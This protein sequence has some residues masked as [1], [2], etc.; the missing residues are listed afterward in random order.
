MRLEFPKLLATRA[1]KSMA[2]TPNSSEPQ[3]LVAYGA[4]NE[5]LLMDDRLKVLTL[6]HALASSTADLYMVQQYCISVLG[7]AGLYLVQQYCRSVLGSERVCTRGMSQV[8]VFKRFYGA[9]RLFLPMVEAGVCLFVYLGQGK[10]VVAWDQASACLRAC[11]S[12]CVCVCVC[13]SVSVSVSVCVCVRTRARACV[14]VC[15]A[16]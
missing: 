11:V 7:A 12:V 4:A 3:L 16:I 2:F 14:R 1:V 15:V 10:G 9:Y 8:C 13:V 6:S 5:T